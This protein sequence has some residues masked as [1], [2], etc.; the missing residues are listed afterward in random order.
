MRCARPGKEILRPASCAARSGQNISFLLGVCF[1]DV[2][3][4]QSV[5]FTGTTKAL[6]AGTLELEDGSDASEHCS[7]LVSLV[8]SM[9]TFPL[10]I[11]AMKN[12]QGVPRI[13][14][15]PSSD[16]TKLGGIIVLIL[17][18]TIWSKSMSWST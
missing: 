16:I 14:L 7:M 3:V 2:H 1:N 5:L 12:D 6:R 17:L 15:I 13:V 10:A 11:Y 8:D 4:V 9:T 18:N